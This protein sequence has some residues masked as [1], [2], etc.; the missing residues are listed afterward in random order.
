[1]PRNAFYSFHYKPDNARASQIR[2]MGVV[3]GNKP[4]ADNDW[5]TITRGGDQAIERWINDQLK[6]RSCAIVLIG[7]NT[8]G[9]KWINYE[10]STA[11]NKKMGVLGIYIHNLRDLSGNQALKGSNP[12]DHVRFTNG[13]KALS[14][15]VVAYDPPYTDSKYVYAHIKNNLPDWIEQ[16]IKIRDSN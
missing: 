15:V 1:M 7:Q 9:R 16:A 14:C 8:A 4:A 12:F 3:D 13:G 2:N 11:W 10:I 6:G 5:E